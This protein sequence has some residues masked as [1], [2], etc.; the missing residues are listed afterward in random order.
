MS[1][2]DFDKPMAAVTDVA[3]R[4]M[5]FSDGRIRRSPPNLPRVDPGLRLARQEARRAHPGLSKCRHVVAES[6]G[7]RK[8]KS[9][10]DYFFEIFS[11]MLRQTSL[12]GA[13]FKD[14]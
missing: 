9:H 10:C 7:L 8:A 2:I 5:T 12:G 3:V 14:L 4:M 1:G 13:S 11:K 6:S